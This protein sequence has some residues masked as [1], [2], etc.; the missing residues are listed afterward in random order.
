MMLSVTRGPLP[1]RIGEKMTI[2][3]H[4]GG[5][6]PTCLAAFPVNVP[7]ST[8]GMPSLSMPLRIPSTGPSHTA[9]RPLL[10]AEHQVTALRLVVFR[11]Y[12]TIS[13]Q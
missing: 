8:K 7:E 4:W 1:A 11:N 6:Y 12:I 9:L 3:R 10:P 2:L 5:I 13:A